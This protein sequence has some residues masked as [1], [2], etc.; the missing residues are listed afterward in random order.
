MACATEAKSWKP[1]TKRFRGAS[2]AAERVA[3]RK[4]EVIDRVYE[5]LD[6]EFLESKHDVEYLDLHRTR[7][8]ARRRFR[9]A[10]RTWRRSHAD[11]T[12][13]GKRRRALVGSSASRAAPRVTRRRLLFRTDACSKRSV[14]KGNSEGLADRVALEPRAHDDDARTD[15]TDPK[16]PGPPPPPPPDTIADPLRVRE[17]A[18]LRAR[19]ERV[20]RR[21]LQAEREER[22]LNETR[23]AAA[24]RDAARSSALSQ[25]ETAPPALVG[26]E[27]FRRRGAR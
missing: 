4:K 15:P 20:A 17:A 8:R 26:T 13:Y 27:S 2:R 23:M 14:Q 12:A 22:R 25:R 16:T 6:L 5:S 1:P 19:L 21:H 7:T 10:W 18:A 9:R 3:R 24:L 11:A